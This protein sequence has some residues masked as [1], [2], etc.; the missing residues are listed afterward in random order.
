M[1]DVLTVVGID[2]VVGSI[3]DVVA[4]GGM[5]VMLMVMMR[6]WVF[7]GLLCEWFSCWI[8]CLPP[9]VIAIICS[10]IHRVLPRRLHCLLIDIKDFMFCIFICLPISPN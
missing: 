1:R 4:T 9:H 7:D 10:F 3:E 6:Y 8:V 2:D 5:L